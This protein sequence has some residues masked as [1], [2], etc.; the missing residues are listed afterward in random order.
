MKC[1]IC[2]K[3]LDPFEFHFVNQFGIVMCDKCRDEYLKDL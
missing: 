3:E 2:G 1:Q